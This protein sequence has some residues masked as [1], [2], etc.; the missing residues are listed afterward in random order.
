MQSIF[1]HLKEQTTLSKQQQNTVLH[2]F[3]GKIVIGKISIK[4]M[5][6]GKV[7]PYLLNKELC[8]STFF[9]VAHEFQ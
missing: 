3:Y 5:H 9:R 2:E 7:I 8:R 1:L 4:V 6:S